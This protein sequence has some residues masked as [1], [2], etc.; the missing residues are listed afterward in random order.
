M[1]LRKMTLCNLS[2]LICLT[3]VDDSARET[4]TSPGTNM[5]RLKT[6]KAPEP[7]QLLALTWVT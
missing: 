4:D 1:A 5:E 3:S 6:V 2:F 7:S